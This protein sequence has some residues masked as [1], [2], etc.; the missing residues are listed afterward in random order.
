MYFSEGE[1]I[2]IPDEEVE[3]KVGPETAHQRCKENVEASI[4]DEH[5]NEVL[6]DQQK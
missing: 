1:S 6:S 2:W 3:P 5:C 4:E